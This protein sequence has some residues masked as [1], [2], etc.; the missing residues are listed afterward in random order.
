VTISAQIVEDSISPYGIRLTTFVL[1]YPR[2]IHS[3]FMTHRA[4]SRNASS[5]RAIPA[6][7]LIS[8]VKEDMAIP[9]EFGSNKP[10][11]QAGEEIKGL[12]LFAAKAIWKLSG[13]LACASASLMAKLGVHKQV[14]NRVIEP[15]SH[16]TVVC[17]ATDF[18]N[19]FALRYHHL[20]Q[21]EI[22]ELAKRMYDAL[23]IS[24]PNTL[25]FGDCHLP[26]VLKSERE[27]EDLPTQIKMSVARCAR[28]SYL[29]H[30]GTNPSKAR[31]IQLHD[32]LLIE[33]PIHASPGEHQ[34]ICSNAIKPIDYSGN[35][36]GYIQYR[37]CLK[38]ETV[39]EF[40]GENDG[41]D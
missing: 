32:K 39:L 10:G 24:E 28:V 1:K 35:L 5:S 34:A 15:W 19:F 3:E 18:D 31:D 2:F 11:M 33:R 37:K 38:N 6:K 36:R 4:F 14:V 23:Q 20:A 26:F 22:K 7:K 25:E 27:K 16:I 9:V 29:N 12:K 30:D 21:P 17:T 40:K 13:K 8:L 41:R